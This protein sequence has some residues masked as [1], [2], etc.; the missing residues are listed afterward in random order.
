VAETPAIAVRRAHRLRGR[1]DLRTRMRPAA[2]GRL[3][4][5][6]LTVFNA[7]GG[8]SPTSPS[9]QTDQSIVAASR[10]TSDSVDAVVEAAL[11]EGEQ[12]YIGGFLSIGPSR[13]M[14][15]CGSESFELPVPPGAPFTLI[16]LSTITRIGNTVSG[17]NRDVSGAFGSIFVDIEGEFIGETLQLRLRAVHEPIGLTYTEEWAA[18]LRSEGDRY[19]FSGQSSGSRK[20][21]DGACVT[22]VT[23]SGIGLSGE[24]IRNPKPLPLPPDATPVSWNVVI[25]EFRTRGPRGVADEFIEIRNDSPATVLI[26]GW[27]LAASTNAGMATDLLTIQP[28]ATIGPGCRYLFVNGRSYSGSVGGDEPYQGEIADDGGVALI[29]NNGTIADAVG[30]STGS[31]FLE[32]L[33]LSALTGNTNRSYERAGGD[34]NDNSLDFTIQTPSNP[35]NR[36]ATC[37]PAG[38]PRPSPAPNPGP[39]PGPGPLPFPVP[40][41]SPVPGSNGGT[42]EA[43]VD[44]VPFTGTITV[45]SIATGNNLV[46]SGTSFPGMVTIFFSTP[47]QVGSQAVGPTGLV[48]GGMVTSPTVGWLAAGPLGSGTVTVSTLTPTSAT[49]TFSFTL[50][51]NSGSGSNK[52]VTNG[53]F[54][55][56]LPTPAP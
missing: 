20:L 34:S 18:T 27:R 55:A 11:P 40:V 19:L 30:M 2:I 16:G 7:C 39:S 31:Q 15:T 32:G 37:T 17:S 53:T 51:P 35:Q 28:G 42:M 4:A 14:V 5:V 33:P 54:T 46:V 23:W 22:D 26:G 8:K 29:R 25:S 48:V 56:H 49:G 21:D 24:I 47:A 50:V 10:L 1:R 36:T 13:A 6:S 43:V 9:A 52:V 45:A 38:S 3:L 44:G 41:P 12:R